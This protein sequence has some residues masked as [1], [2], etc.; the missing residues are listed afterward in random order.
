LTVEDVVVC[1]RDF[2]QENGYPP[3]VQQLSE[4]LG[5]ASKSST[6]YW[7]LKAEEAGLI[8]RVID[9]RHTKAIRIMEG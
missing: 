3:T 2:M 6:T 1:L 9:G 7:L 4:C 5:L 8:E